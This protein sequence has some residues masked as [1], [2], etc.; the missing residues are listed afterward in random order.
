MEKL[1]RS[2]TEGRQ[3]ATQIL[4][5]PEVVDL[6]LS[7]KVRLL[8]AADSLKSLG[9]VVEEFGSTAVIVR[10]IPALLGD[11]VNV[12][13]MIHNLAE[14]MA[15]WGK[16]YSLTE[17]LHLICAT[18]ACHGSVRAGRRLNVEEMNHLLREMEH[19]ER[20]G[21]CNHGR[22]TYVELKLAQIAK[23]FER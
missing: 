20:S 15:E 14:E 3:A 5:I 1:K 4:L 10:E 16:E 23:L 6:S 2:L 18:I 9:L 13:E 7:D 22:P 8:E 21:Q 17:K 19:T 11:K 12:Q